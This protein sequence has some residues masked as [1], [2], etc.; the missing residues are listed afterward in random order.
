MFEAAGIYKS[1]L[2]LGHIKQQSP[3]R[4]RCAILRFPPL[5]SARFQDSW[6]TIKS[7]NYLS[8]AQL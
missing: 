7:Y 5:Q 4:G 1:M 2:D 8:Y 3:D 6:K